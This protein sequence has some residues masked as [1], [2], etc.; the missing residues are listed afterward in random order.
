MVVG[1]GEEKSLEGGWEEVDGYECPQ[2]I[3]V[4]NRILTYRCCYRDGGGVGDG[5]GDDNG[6]G[7]S[8]GGGSGDSKGDGDGDC[9]CDGDSDGNR[10][11]IAHRDA[12]QLW[13]WAAKWRPF[14][15]WM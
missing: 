14:H 2:P 15:F 9:I 5:D 10:E 11:S 12:R 8:V 3:Y 6:D 1:E 4:G 13:R 7:D